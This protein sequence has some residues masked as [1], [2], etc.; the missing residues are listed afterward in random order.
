MTDVTAPGVPD[1]TQQAE[2]GVLLAGAVRAVASAQDV[3][4]EH[5]RA[6]AEEYLAAAPGSLVVPPLWYAFDAVSLDI[7]VSTEVRRSA[8]T[9]DVPAQ[10]QLVCRTLNPITAGLFG[11][12]ASTGTR[13]R[14]ALAPQRL[15][16]APLSTQE[17]PPSPT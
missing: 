6:R 5:A 8:A 1:G 17:V 10:T 14:V 7:Q 3:L 16:P 2:L 12:T 4:D 11:Y 15:V 13:I 9:A